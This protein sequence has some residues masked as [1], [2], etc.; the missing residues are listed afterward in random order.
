MDLPSGCPHRRSHQGHR[1]KRHHERRRSCRCLDKC[2]LA[3]LAN[4]SF[5]RRLTTDIVSGAR[6]RVAIGAAEV[7]LESVTLVGDEVGV[8]V[9]RL[10]LC[11]LWRG[12]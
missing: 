8:A 9:R 2:S 11:E 6:V 3:G 12:R 10:T 7:Q 4:G 1:A 5:A